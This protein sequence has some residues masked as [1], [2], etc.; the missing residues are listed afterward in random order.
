MWTGSVS[1]E[2]ALVS[3]PFQRFVIFVVTLKQCSTQAAESQRAILIA[4]KSLCTQAPHIYRC[5]RW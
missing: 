5:L 2:K 1:A 3:H 4:W